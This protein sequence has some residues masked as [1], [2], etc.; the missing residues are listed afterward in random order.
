MHTYTNPGHS[1]LRLCVCEDSS[2]CVCVRARVR[3]CADGNNVSGTCLVQLDLQ[4]LLFLPH[5]PVSVCHTR[6]LVRFSFFM[7]C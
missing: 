3:A 2:T 5:I 7:D 1:N 6:V 4:G